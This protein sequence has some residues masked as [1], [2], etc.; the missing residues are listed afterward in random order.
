M[1]KFTNIL[2][3]LTLW[4]LMLL[5]VAAFVMVFVGGVVDPE[6]EYKEPV[7][8]DT[9]LYWIG[10]MVA[11]I[12]VITITFA[13]IQFVKSLIATPKQALL[14]LGAISLLVAVFVITYIT[15][16]NSTPLEITGYEGVHN[17]GVWLSIVIMFINTIG[18][19]AGTAV[20]LMLFGGLF[21]VKQ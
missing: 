5:S 16:D 6:A 19:V 9:I 1:L 17:Q 3:K 21:R 13:L 10:I 12:L 11:I 8:L 18:I 20:L 7:F 2:P 15:S 14:S 4:L